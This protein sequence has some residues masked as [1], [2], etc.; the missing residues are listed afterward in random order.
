MD[1]QRAR[2]VS[3]AA[4]QRRRRRP[5]RRRSSSWWPSSPATAST[6]ATPRAYALITYQTA[7][8]KANAPVEFFA[9]S[10]SLDISNTDKLAVFYQDAR[11]VRGQGA[12][13]PTST[14]PAPTSRSRTAR[15]SMRWARCATSA[16]RPWSMWSRCARRAGRSATCSI[17]SSGSIRGR[18]T[19]AR[20]RTWP[21]PAPSTAIHPNRAQIV[22]AADALIG[23]CARASPPSA[24]RRR[25][26]CSA[27]TGRGR[28]PAPAQDRA[29]DRRRTARRGAGGGGLLPVAAI[30]W[31]T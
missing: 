20:W 31:T 19:S 3:G 30:R 28:A 17:S 9:A 25:P 15:C 10:M 18:S 8:L 23:L 6:S 13:R 4:E 16:S 24:P 22:A 12:R 27:A 14:A 2:F 26:A 7:W 21:A 5:G 1:Q 29:L 11:R